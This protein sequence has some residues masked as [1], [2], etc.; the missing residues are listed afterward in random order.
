MDAKQFVKVLSDPKK[1]EQVPIVEL[2]KLVQ[3][4]PFSKNIQLLYHKKLAFLGSTQN[5]QELA[6]LSFQH[7]HPYLLHA[8][9]S[10]ENVEEEHQEINT[11]YQ[12][13]FNSIETTVENDDSP[14]I[15]T[16]LEESMIEAQKIEEK[17][18]SLGLHIVK[19]DEE[20]V[21]AIEEEKKEQVKEFEEDLRDIQ[22]ELDQTPKKIALQTEEEEEEEEEENF[23]DVED[24]QQIAEENDT[25][26]FISVEPFQPL[27]RKKKKDKRKQKKKTKVDKKIGKKEKKKTIKK[28]RQK[29]IEV[30]KKKKKRKQ[31]NIKSAKKTNKLPQEEL[32][33]ETPEEATSYVDWLTR[34][35]S[36][37]EVIQEKAKMIAAKN[38]GTKKKKKKKKKKSKKLQEKIDQS[39]VRNTAIYTE[40]LAILMEKQGHYKKAIKIY[41]QLMHN[42]P[43]KSDYFADRIQ[44]LK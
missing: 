6:V 4:F 20:E 40:T 23:V 7:H 24:E 19:T 35:K 13:L 39:L 21:D 29:E 8:F 30:K 18:Q 3:Q 43:E 37:S 32:I 33:K 27:K 44:K 15:P 36:T 41:K 1:I 42:N 11:L 17:D 9:L 34:L 31:P 28:S 2:E 10:N 25:I 16:E 14:S 5:K 22:E 12:S 38:Q 26:K